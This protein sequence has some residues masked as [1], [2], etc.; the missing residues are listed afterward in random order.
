MLITGCD[1]HPGFQQIAFLDTETGE[2]E[3]RRLEHSQQADG[4][5]R[6]LKEQGISVRVRMEASGQA[7]WFER[8]LAELQFELWE[9]GV[10]LPCAGYVDD[11]PRSPDLQLDGDARAGAWSDGERGCHK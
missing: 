10:A 5:Y 11:D 2:L 9:Q 3:E 4:F 7:C 6:G 8:L 1:Y